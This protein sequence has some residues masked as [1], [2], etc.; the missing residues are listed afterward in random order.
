MKKRSFAEGTSVT[1]RKSRDELEALLDRY[2]A[3]H[4]AFLNEPGRALIAFR[5]ADRNVR[6]SLALP[7]RA[8]PV[9]RTVTADYPRLFLKP[10]FAMRPQP[11]ETKRFIVRLLIKEDQIRP[12]VAVSHSAI[13]G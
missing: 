5:M 13:S 12:D 2:G 11:H 10:Q 7:D 8:D 3:T 9:L 4:T 1:V 6:L